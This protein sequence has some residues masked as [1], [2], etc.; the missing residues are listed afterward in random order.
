MAKE[1][2]LL[3]RS[4]KVDLPD[5]DLYNVSAKVDTGAWT[6]SLHCKKHWTTGSNPVTLHFILGKINPEDPNKEYTTQSFSVRVIKNSSGFAE[7][8]FI[9]RTKITLFGETYETEFSLSNRSTMKH[10]ILLGRKFL[11]SNFLID[12]TKYNLSYKQK[13]Q[14]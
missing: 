6:C 13:A 4:D 9:I 5:L 2:K 8:R 14:K 12:V 11:K 1:K 3:G 7:K 10:P